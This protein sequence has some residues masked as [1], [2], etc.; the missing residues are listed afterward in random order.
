MFHATFV[1]RVESCSIPYDLSQ[2]TKIFANT[3]DTLRDLSVCDF[4]NATKS[5]SVY[6]L[7]AILFI[8]F[9]K[10]H[11]INRVVIKGICEDFCRA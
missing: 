7:Y 8:A 6:P 1:A 9:N 4:L 2:A 11:A 5:H 3:Y 10:S